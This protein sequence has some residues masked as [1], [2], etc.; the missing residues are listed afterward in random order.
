[1]SSEEI[2][3]TMKGLCYKEYGE[4][5][6]VIE[7]LDNIPVPKPGADQLLIR[8]YASAIDPVDYKIM[9]GNLK[10]VELGRDFPIIPGF[11][12]SGVVVARGRGCKREDIEVGHPVIAYAKARERGAL[13]EYV[14]ISENLCTPRPN[15]M[16]F[17]EAATLPLV[18]TT[19]WQALYDVAKLSLGESVLI[20]GGTTATGMAGIQIAAALGAARIS[21]TCSERNFEF[22]RNLGA[23]DP[24]DYRSSDWREDLRE[25]CFDV[26]Y[27]CV[28]GFEPYEACCD[29]ERQLMNLNR[30]GERHCY[31][32]ICGDQQGY[33]GVA[34]MAKS[35]AQILSRKMASIVPTSLGGTSPNYDLMTAKPT[36]QTIETVAALAEG[37]ARA[38][39]VMQK[40]VGVGNFSLPEN[41]LRVLVEECYPMNEIERVRAAFERLMSGR[42]RGKQVIVI[43]DEENEG[44]KEVVE[45]K[46]E[47]KE[48]EGGQ[49]MKEEK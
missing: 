46:K 16:S 27:D 32:T 28:G 37:G 33:L 42:S 12:I 2:P 26:V 11:N 23:T 5:T 43:H 14:C 1:M 30:N 18:G 34:R 10:I 36:F 48:E 6:K 35:G 4:A 15:G 13:A 41:P 49:E 8:Q 22:V 39:L 38:N 7:F 19:S 9:C 21:C 45:K 47:E 40:L 3:N 20:L 24:I 17:I 25:A 29:G 44:E 31:V